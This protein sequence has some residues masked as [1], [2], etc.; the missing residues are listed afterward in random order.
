MM[1][2]PT[3]ICPNCGKEFE[4]NQALTHALE[5]R[6]SRQLSEE[7][8]KRLREAEKIAREKAVGELAPELADLKSQLSVKEK[9]LQ[10][11]AAEELKLRKDKQALEERAAQI[12]LEVAR[13]IEEQR[14][15]IAAAAE[16]RK[17]QEFKL[18]DAERDQR[19]KDLAVQ[20]ETMRKQEDLLRKQASDAESRTRQRIVDAERQAAEKARSEALAE[21]E[22]TAKQLEEQREKIRELT[23]REL[24]LLKEKRDLE[25]RTEQLDLEVA[26]KVEEERQNIATDVAARKD[27]EFRLKEAEKEHKIGDLLKQIDE[28]KRRAEQG[29]MQTQGEVQELELEKMLRGEFT[30]D[31]VTEVSKGVRGADCIHEVFTPGG[32]SCGKILWES[33]R[34]KNWNNAWVDKLK[35]DQ[36]EA[37][38][39]VAVIVSQALPEG[40]KHVGHLG[41]VWV[42]DFASA[43][44]M[45]YILRAGLLQVAVA[46]A[47]VLGKG[48]K[49]EM[50]YEYL[51]GVEFRNAV[52]GVIE[53][54]N[55]MR[56]DLETERR[57]ME[58]LWTKREKQATKA[59]VNLAHMYGG[60]Q[61][62]VGKTL[63][64]IP[65]LELPG[66]EG[67]E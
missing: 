55:Q 67:G 64:A 50:L 22:S 33:K 24:K 35:E 3:V 36:R 20:V 30:H 39:E 63:P 65:T 53:A 28:L 45:A 46:R 59:I 1:A 32:Q 40:L 27:E 7:Y 14:G 44:G 34:T 61:G 41:G 49:M 42:C 19:L 38:A 26:R 56:E 37:K 62:I 52:Q 43:V 21:L 51:T 10:E 57:A 9:K 2:S 8:S 11:A 58:R 6:I 4:L 48:E 15:K 47:S 31:T 54:F 12:E 16:A 23:S 18:K 25:T 13:K 60:I 66:E 17:E 5:E 29:S